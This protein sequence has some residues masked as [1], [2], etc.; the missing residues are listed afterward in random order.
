MDGNSEM[1][2]YPGGASLLRKMLN[3]NYDIE[4]FTKDLMELTVV[5]EN[6]EN[7]PSGIEGQLHEIA[8]LSNLYT[9]AKVG[10]ELFTYS[11]LFGVLRKVKG[12]KWSADYVI[13][14]IQELTNFPQF[15]FK[16]LREQYAD[17]LLENFKLTSPEYLVAKE[18]GDTAT[19]EELEQKEKEFISKAETFWKADASRMWSA[20]LTNSIVSRTIRQDFTPSNSSVF[21]N[22]SP[23]TIPHV[24][25]AY[26]VLFK[27]KRL[28]EG[29]FAVHYPLVRDFVSSVKNSLQVATSFAEE[30][31]N[32]F[33]QDEFIKFL[34]SGTT[35]VDGPNTIDLNVPPTKPKYVGEFTLTGID[36]WAMGVAENVDK[37]KKTSPN[38][39]IREIEISNDYRGV[40][41]LLITSDKESDPETFERIRQGMVDLYESSPEIAIDIF[42]YAALTQG[43]GFGRTSFSKIFPD[44][45]LAAFSRAL[46]DR[47]DMVMPKDESGEI[48]TPIAALNLSRLR[49]VF[50]FQL[51]KNYPSRIKFLRGV[52]EE[53]TGS[54]INYYG[55]RSKVYFGK[56]EGPNG[57]IY[58]DR[59]Y[60]RTTGVEFHQYINVFEKLFAKVETTEDFVYYRALPNTTSNKNY[61]FSPEFLE[62]EFALDAILN[63]SYGLEDSNFDTT[64]RSIYVKGVVQKYEE[65]DQIAIADFSTPFPK[66]VKLVTVSKVIKK[67]KGF[68]YL[69]SSSTDVS[70]VSTRSE[71]QDKA[72]LSSYIL[73]GENRVNIIATSREG[74]IARAEKDRNNTLGVVADY[75]PMSKNYRNILVLPLNDFNSLSPEEATANVLEAINNMPK[76]PKIVLEE[77]ILSLLDSTHPKEALTIASA[78]NSKFGIVVP[79]LKSQ[80]ASSDPEFLKQYQRNVKKKEIIAKVFRNNTITVENGVHTIKDATGKTSPST[81]VSIPNYPLPYALVLSVDKN[82]VTILPFDTPVFDQLTSANYTE[83]ELNDLIDSTNKCL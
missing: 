13:R 33:I 21:V 54:Y 57:P 8:M 59:K 31:D 78:L 41:R 51:I 70:T 15:S 75:I 65:G 7:P 20:S 4:E 29:A 81:I 43:L 26:S 47:I 76:L 66:S 83:Q 22:A 16:D 80:A 74:A 38:R 69:Y 18:I 63:P 62:K 36:A 23:L 56:E 12:K 60:P 1:S 32:E 27:F 67:E 3:P 77:N 73:Q 53:A 39:F 34:S 64:G 44:S 24:F 11:Q 52:R 79:S 72:L 58:F 55:S 46:D 49:D 2:K 19:M 42:K 9:L 48:K 30:K 14:R 50:A 45:L 35:F 25:S 17:K 10:D 71:S 82:T 28:V 37:L 40:P 5:P 68:E 61:N 6:I